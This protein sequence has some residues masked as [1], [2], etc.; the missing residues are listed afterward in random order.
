MGF[1]IPEGTFLNY[2]RIIFYSEFLY[3]SLSLFCVYLFDET[4][5]RLENRKINS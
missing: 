4:Q 5:K 1:D 2:F 3:T